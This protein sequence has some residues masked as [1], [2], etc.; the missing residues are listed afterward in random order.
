MASIHLTERFCELASDNVLTG[1]VIS[2]YSNELII[3]I[4]QIADAVF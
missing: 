1:T 4:C 3:F 2:P